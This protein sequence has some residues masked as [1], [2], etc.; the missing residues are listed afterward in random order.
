[1]V[2]TRFASEVEVFAVALAKKFAC[3]I[4][5]KPVL[6]SEVASPARRPVAMAFTAAS[7]YA[8]VAS[9]RPDSKA[10]P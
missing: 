7:W 4:R 5:E 8:L 10:L 9:S 1:M 3:A 2:V 6:N